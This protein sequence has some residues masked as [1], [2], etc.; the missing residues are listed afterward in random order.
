VNCHFRLTSW[1]INIFNQKRPI[2]QNQPFFI[3][4]YHLSGWIGRHTVFPI[5]LIPFRILF[6]IQSEDFAAFQALF[7]CFVFKFLITLFFLVFRHCK[8]IV[9]FKIAT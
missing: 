9:G 7:H 6:G 3:F 1:P 8:Y 2:H 4:S 5:I